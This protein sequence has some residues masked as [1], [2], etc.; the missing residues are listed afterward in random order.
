MRQDWRA[1]FVGREAEGKSVL[2]RMIAVCAA[3]GVHPFTHK[4]IASSW[5]ND[6]HGLGQ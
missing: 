3:H 4:A 1:V 5:R 6:P 2:L